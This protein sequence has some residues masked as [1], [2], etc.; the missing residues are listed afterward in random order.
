MAKR[1]L[2]MTP[3]E[4]TNLTKEEL[5][6]AIAANEGRMLASETIGITLPL[7]TDVTNAEF[8]ASMGADLILL[9]MFDVREPRIMALPNVEPMET[10][11]EVKR[12]TGRTDEV[13]DEP[14]AVRDRGERGAG[15]EHGR[16]HDC[17]DRESGKRSEQ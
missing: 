8:A 15:A 5:L 7:L 9:N 2:N 1:I 10:V 6:S 13:G 12:L 16:G 3:L 14:R 17:A 11:R 4:L